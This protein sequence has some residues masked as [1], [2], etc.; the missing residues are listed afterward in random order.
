MARLNEPP[1]STDSLETL[2][3]KLLRQNRDLAKS[4]NVRALRIRELEN[5]CACM[6]SEN[7]ELRSRILELEK[8]A[9]D[10]DNR[11]IADHALA[12]KHKLESQLTEWGT[13]L[14]GL[15]LEPPMKKLSPRIRKSTKPRLSFSSARPSPSQRRLRDIARDIEE[16]GHISE[17]KSYPRRTMNP[18]QILALRSEAGS[19]GNSAESPELGPPPISKFIDEDPVKVDSPSQSRSAPAPAPSPQAQID[20]SESLPSPPSDRVVRRSPSPEKKKEPKTQAEEIKP[21]DAKPQDARLEEIK[22]LESKPEETKPREAKPQKL[23]LSEKKAPAVAPVEPVKTGSKRK[24]AAREDLENS[25]PQKITNENLPPKSVTEKQS[26]RAKAGGKTLKEL[27]NMR[28]EARE[29]SANTTNTRKPLAARSTND[30]MSSPKKNSRPVILDDVAAA[31]ADLLRSKASQER[32]KSKTKNPPPITIETV[33]DP[34]PSAPVTCELGTPFTALLSPSSPEPISSDDG[35][36]GATPPPADISSTR[37]PARLSR[38]SRTAVSYA[39]PNLR[40]KMRRPTKE[41][42][43]AV[44]GEGKFARRSSQVEPVAPESVVKVKHESDARDSWKKLPSAPASKEY[45][46]DSIPASPLAGKGSPPE[47]LPSSVATERRRHPSTFIKEAGE[48]YNDCRKVEA[49]I[50]NEVVDSDPVSSA[51]VDVYEFTPSSPQ[52]EK[53]TATETKK[54]PGRPKNSR[55]VSV[56]VQNDEGLTGKERSAARRRSMML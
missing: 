16:L 6:L 30:D 52:S 49:R 25:R 7:L 29:R 45:A 19:E 27:A 36:R 38:R 12:I 35:L 43:D 39:E 4:N 33:L 40:D 23:V 47:D 37:E 2:R 44:T 50:K 48:D 54:R 8:E 56:A 15:G 46:P 55:R 32:A 3:K 11:R 10:N 22:P 28:K 18:E 51:E 14:A 1:V 20:I 53:Q 26:I 17:H 9:E 24:L 31:K 34:E 42:Y 13:L 21:Q 41:L 5:D